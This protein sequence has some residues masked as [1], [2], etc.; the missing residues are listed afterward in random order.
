MNVAALP[1]GPEKLP[2]GVAES[3]QGAAAKHGPESPF[4]GEVVVG[5]ERAGG[6]ADA[7]GFFGPQQ[8]EAPRHRGPHLH[9]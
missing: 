3:P 1:V 9:V 5:V 6:R 2:D 7:F 4:S 8:H